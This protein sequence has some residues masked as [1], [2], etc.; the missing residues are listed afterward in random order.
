MRVLR[1][2]P[3]SFEK[4]G[5]AMRKCK[6]FQPEWRAEAR[7]D[8]MQMFLNLICGGFLMKKCMMSVVLV[9][10]LAVPASAA[11]THRYDFEKDPHDVVGGLESTLVGDAHVTGGAL[12]LDGT[13]DLLEMDGPGTAIN[14]Y[15]AF[16]L[17]MWYTPN[18]GKNT[19]YTMLAYY[20]GNQGS[21]GVNYFFMSTARGD[22]VSRAAISTGNTSDPWATEN[23]VNGP[24]YDDDV[25][26]HM[27]ATL[28][29]T[30][31]SF[32]V[33]GVYQ[34][35]T[36]LT[37]T[38]KMTD[39][40]QNLALLG[41]GGYLNDPEWAGS[42]H[43]F[44]VY[45]KALTAAE[46]RFTKFF[47]P[48]NPYPIVIRN[49]SPADG[50][51]KVNITPTLS[52][53]LEPGISAASYN[54][55][56]GRDPNIADPNRADVSAIST[57]VVPG[58][59][60]PAYTIPFEKA[61]QFSTTYYWRVDTVMEDST[62]YQG[63]GMSFTTIPQAP[64]FEVQPVSNYLFAGQ[65]AQFTAQCLSLSPVS[66][67][68]WY[69]VST[70]ADVEIT[71]GPDVTI[72]TVTEGDLT[73]STLTIANVEAADEGTYYAKA[74]NEVGTTQTDLARLV[75]KKLV[76]YWPFDGNTNDS[77]GNGYHG[78]GK[79]GSTELSV[80]LAYQTGVVGQ[81]VYLPGTTHYIDLVDGLA[82]DFVGGL[83]FNLW[84]YP[85]T[86]ANWARFLSCN[87]GADSDNIFLSRVGT[88]TTLRFD[89]Y[90]G[91]TN[92]GYVDAADALALNVWQMFTVT[93]NETGAVTIYKNG[94]PVASGTVQIPN[95]VKRANNWI[96]R[97][98]WSADAYYR[99]L[100]DEMRIYNYALTPA[101]VA[102]LY[103][104][105]RTDEFICVP[106]SE[107]PLSY[108]LTGDCRVNM[109]DLAEII[110]WWTECMR[111]PDEA[112]GGK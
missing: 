25:Q 75:L 36:A 51:D 63:V 82:D 26:H 66:W 37:G 1:T 65:T 10:L 89:V 34:G 93:M 105:V 61:L 40:A 21:N 12:V 55:Y 48:D 87:N 68:K 44:R 20:G 100:L 91:S 106:D 67:V 73:A 16:S 31:V 22:N 30:H 38:N 42:I 13:D 47:G 62:V 18:A 78:T 90:K 92:A 4:N 2:A 3:A 17:E 101:E 59:T 110:G 45:D 33:D 76:A 54:L 28:T 32:F 94:L 81:A 108:D 80:T 43:E 9:C 99:G 29:Q 84:A 23:G 104:N 7:N 35:T 109:D 112:C 74:R 83:T 97:S 107:N 5:R 46:V 57:L 8:S 86:A 102:A 111:V 41:R 50:T 56:I 98:A 77:S 15:E 64:V 88:G 60:T 6:N 39:I 71:A 52:W 96:G 95:V 79:D 11:I 19:G 58:L 70:P 49:M 24:E 27:V 85:Q 53:T 14:T 103:T 72:Q 69:K